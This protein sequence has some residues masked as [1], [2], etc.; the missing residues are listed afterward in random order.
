MQTEIVK[1]TPEIAESYLSKN[2]KNRNIAPSRVDGYARDMVTGRWLFNPNPIVFDTEGVLIDGQHRLHAI[3]K[4]KIAVEMLVMRGAPCES[5]NIIDFNKPRS[6]GDILQLAGFVHSNN[7]AAL[8]KR[9]IAWD[10]GEKS[11]ISSHQ[12]GGGQSSAQYRNATKPEVVDYAKANYNYLHGIINEAIQIYHSGNIALLSP[13]EIGF[14]LHI[15]APHEKAL[16]FIGKIISGV[17]LNEET[18]EL[19]MRKVLERVRF[20]KDMM[21]SPID[22]LRYFIV[23]FD[24][25]LKGANVK[26]LRIATK[27]GDNA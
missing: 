13:S 8:A 9:I 10:R 5:I 4:A 19:A 3:V 2:V 12:S 11:I 26:T 14:L 17:G 22:F 15:L 24:K 7:L 23:A 25:H 18:A 16:V 1:I 6:S 27:E 21:V 20:K